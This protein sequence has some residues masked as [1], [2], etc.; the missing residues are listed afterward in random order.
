MRMKIWALTAA[1][2]LAGTIAA[3]AALPPPPDTKKVA[4]TDTYFGVRPLSRAAARTL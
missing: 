3:G 1:T 2:V 4:V